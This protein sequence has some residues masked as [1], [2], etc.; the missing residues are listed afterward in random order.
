MLAAGLLLSFHH[1]MSIRAI[2]CPLA[3]DAFGVSTCANDGIGIACCSWIIDSPDV[4]GSAMNA[5]VLSTARTLAYFPCVEFLTT[6]ESRT[7]T[8]PNKNSV[9]Q[10]VKNSHA[11]SISSTA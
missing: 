4:S 10:N 1:E 6:H 7:F 8:S 11:E 9:G 3:L 5:A 2:A